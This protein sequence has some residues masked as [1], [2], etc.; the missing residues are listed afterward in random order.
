MVAAS[1]FPSWQST[2]LSLNHSSPQIT[3]PLDT[4]NMG[5]ALVAQTGRRGKG[6][7]T[8][9]S[10]IELY[11]WVVSKLLSVSPFCSS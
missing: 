6:S 9:Y 2:S 8:S 5:T 4:T 1:F 3:A 10:S 11:V 7:N